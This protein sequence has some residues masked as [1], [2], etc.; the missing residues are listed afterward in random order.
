M[1]KHLGKDSR[2]RSRKQ[3]YERAKNKR[4]GEWSG[5]EAVSDGLGGLRV[6][7]DVSR[8]SDPPFWG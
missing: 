5:V 2:K 8:H 4:L 7:V 1:R 6:G 3:T